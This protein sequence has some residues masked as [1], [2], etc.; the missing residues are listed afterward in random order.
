LSA[1]WLV[2]AAGAA[3]GTVALIAHNKAADDSLNMLAVLVVLACLGAAW[4][5][6]KTRKK[7]RKIDQA[8][9]AG[10]IG[11]GDSAIGPG[12]DRDEGLAAG[13]HNPSPWQRAE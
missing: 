13:Q 5:A 4:D 7:F 9:K 3:A 11:Y 10:S 8:A 2:A 12:D 1:V 6:W